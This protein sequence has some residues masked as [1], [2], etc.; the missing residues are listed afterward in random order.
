M[1]KTSIYGSFNSALY[2]I[3]S[4]FNKNFYFFSQDAM[5]RSQFPSETFKRPEKAI[6]ES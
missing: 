3:S 6:L 2:I 5:L 1:A 4:V